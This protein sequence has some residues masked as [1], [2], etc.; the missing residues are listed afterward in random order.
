MVGLIL[1]ATFSA[2]MLSGSSNDEFGCILATKKKTLI[3]PGLLVSLQV[4]P[5]LAVLETLKA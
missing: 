1:V 3:G 5:V 4:R 2:Q